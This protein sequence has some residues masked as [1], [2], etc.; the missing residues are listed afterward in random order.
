MKFKTLR[1]EILKFYGIYRL[2]AEILKFS[3]R[4][5][6]TGAQETARNNFT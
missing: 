4:E 3:E 2:P 5:L 1:D 6:V